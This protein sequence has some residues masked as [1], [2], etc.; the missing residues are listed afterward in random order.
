MRAG[1]PRPAYKKVPWSDTDNMLNGLNPRIAL[2]QTSANF[3][4]PKMCDWLLKEM[5]GAPDYGGRARCSS[6]P[7]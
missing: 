1:V 2:A 4:D 3:Y 7:R 5:K 6:R